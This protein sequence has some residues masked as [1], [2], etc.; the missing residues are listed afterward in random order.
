[1]SGPSPTP[2]EHHLGD[3]LAALVDGELDHDERE[4]V[5]A[6]LATCARCKAEAD[7]Q[8][9]LKSVFAEVAPPPPSAGLLARLQSLPGGGCTSSHDDDDKR[10]PF[11]RG[12]LGGGGQGS[13]GHGVFDA[14]DAH[15]PHMDTFRYAGAHGASVFPIHEVGKRES[16]RSP[17][18]ARRFAFAAAGAVSLA[19]IALGGAL[20]AA[21]GPGAPARNNVVPLRV[22][23]SSTAA[24]SGRRQGIGGGPLSRTGTSARAAAAPGTLQARNLPVHAALSSRTFAA[25]SFAAP[26]YAAPS[27][28]SLAFGAPVFPADAVNSAPPAPL[29]A[30]AGA[31]R[32]M[33]GSMAPIGLSGG[34]GRLSGSG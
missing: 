21:S 4:R 32:T 12:F 18:R 24:E 1:M 14:P 6:H 9:R 19:A 34:P 2:S 29:A 25:P 20:P 30:A 10:G 33:N 8:R 23:G 31:L 7:C 17:W 22:A 27:V 28:P 15:G 5:L 26:P 16:E 3:R 13:F 11:D